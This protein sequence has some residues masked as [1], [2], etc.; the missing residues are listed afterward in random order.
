MSTVYPTYDGF[1]GHE[2]QTIHLRR[3]DE[4]DSTHPLVIGRPELFGLDLESAVG[5]WMAAN[6]ETG[7]RYEGMKLAELR[8]A[9][10]AR[11][12]PTSGNKPDLV[13]R[14][15]VADGGADD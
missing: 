5:E 13:A 3:E 8:D 7:D 12:L 11:Q 14:L 2:G 10:A 9:L 6:S 4:W 1:V 15:R